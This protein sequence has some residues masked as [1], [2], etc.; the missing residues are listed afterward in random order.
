MPTP[1]APDYLAA[2][3]AWKQEHAVWDERYN[4][5]V[6]RMRALLVLKDVEVPEGWDVEQEV[7]EEM[8]FFDPEWAPTPGS[9]GRKLDYILWD[10]MGDGLDAKRIT[11]AEAEL[12]GIDLEEVNANEASFRDQV[13]GETDPEVAGEP[14][15]D[16]GTDN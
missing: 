12:S 16:E 15:G 7:G 10:I 4:E 3:E 8:R 2:V 13:E 11:D 9:L 5:E 14:P 6:D 1:H